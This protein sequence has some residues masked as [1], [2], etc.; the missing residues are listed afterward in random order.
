MLYIISLG[1]YDAQTLIIIVMKK[2]NKLFSIKMV[3]GKETVYLTTVSAEQ[4]HMAVA[5]CNHSAAIAKYS[6]LGYQLKIEDKT[7]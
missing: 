7:L 1:L 3:K 5:M 2:N 6:L 4:N